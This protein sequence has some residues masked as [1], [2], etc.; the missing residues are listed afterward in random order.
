[1][2]KKPT[3]TYIDEEQSL[4]HIKYLYNERGIFLLRNDNI[5]LKLNWGLDDKVRVNFYENEISIFPVRVLYNQLKKMN[6]QN[7]NIWF[8]GLQMQ[9]DI[10]T[11]SIKVQSNSVVNIW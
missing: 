1:M 5:Q 8:T 7:S 4:Y 3:L 6:W 2:E 9:I 11:I 10:N